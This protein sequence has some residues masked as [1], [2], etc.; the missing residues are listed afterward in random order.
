[1]RLVSLW[2]KCILLSHFF[3]CPFMIV[4]VVNWHYLFERF[5][6]W[7]ALC[8]N[9]HSCDTSYSV[10]LA[11]SSDMIF[12]ESLD[13]F[14]YGPGPDSLCEIVVNDLNFWE[15]IIELLNS[16][17]F[18]IILM[19]MLCHY[20][21]HFSF[22]KAGNI[23]KQQEQEIKRSCLLNMLLTSWVQKEP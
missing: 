10:K 11:V 22:R 19:Q 18:S 23:E 16:S 13:E 3:V 14:S 6:F 4:S 2:L 8:Q 12:F 17:Y 7:Q 9:W 5:I 21:A 15:I 20:F 1:M